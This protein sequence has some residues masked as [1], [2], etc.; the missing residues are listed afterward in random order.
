MR[1][2]LDTGKSMDDVV[3]AAR[4]PLHFKQR[5]AIEQQCR[6]WTLPQLGAALARIA[7]AAKAARLNSALEGTLAE[8]LLLDIS[9]IA[10]DKSA[11]PP[12]PS[13]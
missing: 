3:R 6:A 4:P 12:L 9:S 5:E 2:A 1:G 11:G 7:D 10:R 13:R 8:K